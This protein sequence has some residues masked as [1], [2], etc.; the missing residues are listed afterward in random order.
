MDR[1]T[2]CVDHN[3]NELRWEKCATGQWVHFSDVEMLLWE[4]NAQK[5]I[6]QALENEI[7]RLSKL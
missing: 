2:V 3:Y 6:N 1:Y 4:L 7:Q 5:T